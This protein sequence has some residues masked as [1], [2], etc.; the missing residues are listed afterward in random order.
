VI[1][2]FCPQ[3]GF[4]FVCPPSFRTL[5]LSALAICKKC[6]TVTIALSETAAGLYWLASK[7]ELSGDE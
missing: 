4:R 5:G 3:C 2:L 7:Q 1:I 6:K